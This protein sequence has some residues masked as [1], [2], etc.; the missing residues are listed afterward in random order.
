[1][2]EKIKVIFISSYSFSGS[3]MLD[4]ILG[5]NDQAISGGEIF[6]FRPDLLAEGSKKLCSCGNFTL[7]CKFWKNIKYQILEN[8]SV[9]CWQLP[10]LKIDKLLR[11]YLHADTSEMEGYHNNC[12]AL[13]HAMMKEGNASVFIDS[14]KNIPRL[15]MLLYSGLYDLRI[16]LLKRSARGLLNSLRKRKISLVKALFY[17]KIYYLLI[18]R[19]IKRHKLD[20]KVVRVSYEELVENPEHEI[21]IIC[22]SIGMQFQHD[23]LKMQPSELH[24]LSG[25]KEAM[26]S[27]SSG[28]RSSHEVG[29]QH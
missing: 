3:T 1:M 26:D 5:G 4:M 7:E 10:K 11:P 17:Q 18:N 14:S 25:N 28:I 20:S 16:I 6:A 15:L 21:R 19:L 27:R 22:D 24:I 13:I 29:L 23:M 12:Y 2:K 8:M 9:D